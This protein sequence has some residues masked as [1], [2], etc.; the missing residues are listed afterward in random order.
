MID[1]LYKE[2]YSKRKNGV[3]LNKKTASMFEI[4]KVMWELKSSFERNGLNKKEVEEYVDFITEYVPKKI[5]LKELLLGIGG[6]GTSNII[7]KLFPNFS[8]DKIVSGITEWTKQRLTPSEKQSDWTNQMWES[9]GKLISIGFTIFL[10]FLV[11]LLFI[12]V[13][14]NIVNMDNMYINSQKK[15]VLKRIIDIWDYSENT[16]TETLNEI[17]SNNEDKT[18]YIFTKLEWSRTRFEK[19]LDEAVGA[20]LNKYHY[21]IVNQKWLKWIKPQKLKGFVIGSIMPTVFLFLT[22]L[23]MYYSFTLSN[24]A[25]F[26]NITFIIVFVVMSFATTYGFIIFYSSQLDKLESNNPEIR[27]SN[28]KAKLLTYKRVPR[29]NKKPSTFCAVILYVVQSVIYV[30]LGRDS[31]YFSFK[32]LFFIPLVLIIWSIFYF[33]S[34]KVGIDSSTNITNEKTDS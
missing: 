1:K 19:D 3:I 7:V 6:L 18:K 10:M 16:E 23:C 2:W 22:I 9:Y 12:I 24:E 29:T 28:D 25:N 11:I 31:I 4:D 17:F 13:M 21:F 26:L 8:N 27:I 33:L 15:F 5:G 30:F 20:N 32:I 34:N 14:Y